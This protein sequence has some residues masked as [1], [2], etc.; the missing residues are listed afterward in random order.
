MEIVT[1]EFS[2]SARL[3]PT[4][5]NF[6]CMSDLEFLSKSFRISNSIRVTLSIHN[7]SYFKKLIYGSQKAEDI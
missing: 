1:F 6:Y 3:L 2:E 5:V 7:L 4:V